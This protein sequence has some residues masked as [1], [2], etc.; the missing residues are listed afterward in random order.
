MK[1]LDLLAPDDDEEL[2]E[3]SMEPMEVAVLEK[4]YLQFLHV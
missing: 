2:S 3:M 1:T 4:K